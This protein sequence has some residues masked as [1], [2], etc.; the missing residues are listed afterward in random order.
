MNHGDA[1]HAHQGRDQADIERN[2]A[3]LTVQ[4]RVLAESQKLCPVSDEPLGSMGKPLKIDVGERAVF[5]CC[6]GCE[7]ALKENPKKFLAK[8]PPVK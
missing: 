4:D 1:G 7:D 6:E 3:Q 5:I 8:L 2:L